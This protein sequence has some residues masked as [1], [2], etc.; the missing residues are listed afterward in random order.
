MSDN[1]KPED[2]KGGPGHIILLAVVF[3]VPVLKPAWTLG[4]GGEARRWSP[5]NRP[6]G[7]TS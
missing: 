3:A 7:R 4:G 1:E 5:W 2:L 6:T